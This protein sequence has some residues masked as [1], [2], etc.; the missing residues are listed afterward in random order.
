M[1]QPNKDIEV[2]PN[3]GAL[4]SRAA[5]EF[6]SRANAAV[7]ERGV[8]SVVLSGGSTPKGLFELLAGEETFR[9]EI[10]WTQSHFFWV[11]ERHVPP[12]HPDSNFRLAW[13]TLL[14]KVP[15]PADNIHRIS[16][17]L[18]DA[19]EAAERYESTLRNFFQLASG[20]FPRFDLILL[21]MGADGH[22]ASLF[23][24]TEALQEC[25]RSVAANWVERLHTWRITL[26][27]PVLNNAACILFLVS[28][29][30]KAQ[31][32]REIFS[33]KTT[34]YPAQLV[35]PTRGRLLWLVDQL[36]EFGTPKR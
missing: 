35:N 13:E 17:E 29:L 15:V 26:T 2:L 11:D 21:G 34:S 31:T 9:S 33:N 10:P 22:T 27:L 4:Y 32:L 6:L 19:H 28:G 25:R 3:P 20:E 14:S 1:K 12:D 16:S 36:V 24:G 18:P 7:K 23:P 5:Q 30:E 8:F